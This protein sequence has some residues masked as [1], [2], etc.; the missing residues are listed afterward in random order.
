MLTKEVL[1]FKIYRHGSA[2]ISSSDEVFAEYRNNPI[3]ERIG[4]APFLEPTLSILW[5][6]DS[7]ITALFGAQAQRV[8]FETV[9]R[10]GLDVLEGVLVVNDPGPVELGIVDSRGSLLTQLEERDIIAVFGGFAVNTEFLSGLLE[11]EHAIRVA[12]DSTRVSVV[13]VF[14]TGCH[15]TE[16]VLCALEHGADEFCEVLE[17]AVVSVSI[18]FG[19]SIEVCHSCCSA[20]RRLVM[21]LQCSDERFV[22]VSA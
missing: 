15:G 13:G 16:G 11:Q 7:G 4:L 10:H 8:A 1:F 20:A 6:S 9:L 2:N 18:G 21:R 22:L 5:L 3:K 14:V 12:R 19:V 17:F